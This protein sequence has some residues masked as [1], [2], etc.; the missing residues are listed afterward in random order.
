MPTF[1]RVENWGER[2]Q[3]VVEADVLWR[4]AEQVREVILADRAPAGASGWLDAVPVGQIELGGLSSTPASPPSR[5]EL[6]RVHEDL[7]LRLT[8]MR[9]RMVLHQSGMT[10]HVALA[11][12]VDKELARFGGTVNRN[13]AAFLESIEQQFRLGHP[14]LAAV[15]VAH[16]DGYFRG[17][18]V[19]TSS[20]TSSMVRLVES[21]TGKERP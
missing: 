1:V 16:V 2:G 4:A 6:F 7:T 3:P 5:R 19:M 12:Y 9:A 13:R 17:L 10:G 11:A 21:R 18:S 14:E 8:R 15:L 20:F